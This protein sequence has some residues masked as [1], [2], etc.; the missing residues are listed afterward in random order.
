MD[1]GLHPEREL[2]LRE[3]TELANALAGL[4]VS[5]GGAAKR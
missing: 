5:S 2:D 4:G 3:N 1:K